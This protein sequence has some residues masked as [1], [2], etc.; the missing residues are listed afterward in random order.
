MKT[1]IL[2]TWAAICLLALTATAGYRVWADDAAANGPA[3]KLDKTYTGTVV[4]VDPKESVL[5]VRGL[6]PFS[7]K[8]FNLGD[9]CTYTI[10]G[11]DN[12]AV[13]DLRPGQ[14][15]AVGYQEAN[16]VPVA[17]RVTQQPMQYEGMVKAIDPKAQ[18]LTLHVGIM[19]KTFQ[20]P[21]ECAV[22]LRGD[23]S[24]TVADIQAGDHVT[25]TYEVPEGK[26]TARGIAQT[27]ATFTGDLTAIDLDQK[28]L[29]A[30]A[31][32]STKKFEV[33]DDCAIV[34]N[35]KPDG[36]LT[37]LRPGESLAISYD[38][39]NGVNIVN[40][41]APGGDQKSSVASSAPTQMGY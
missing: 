10:V 15:V 34:I 36:K 19:D 11:Q 7:H 3:A 18:T 40:R 2:R 37:D 9:T 35:G 25:V 21:A 27:S 23:K 26:A 1:K 32:F 41:I 6:L 5:E 17:D 30:K 22:T 39:V 24:G 16:G 29:K 20:I 31:T 8:Q 38:E 4:T 28:T 12:G 13:S 14:R 33:G